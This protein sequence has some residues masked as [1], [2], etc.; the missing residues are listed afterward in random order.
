ME[1]EP[2]RFPSRK[3]PAV[4]GFGT[5]TVTKALGQEPAGPT[6]EELAAA[7]AAEDEAATGKKGKKGSPKGK[8]KGGDDVAD[9]GAAEDNGDTTTDDCAVT[10]LVSTAHRAFIVARDSAHAFLSKAFT[11]QV[12]A[13]LT[14]CFFTERPARCSPIACSVTHALLSPRRRSRT[15]YATMTP[16]GMTKKRGGTTGLEWLTRCATTTRSSRSK[17]D[18]SLKVSL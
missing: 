14:L 3:W 4:Q 16:C 10:S 11:Q 5:L 17:L 15:S 12:R 6:E 2:L 13:P 7:A 8:G 18:L 1:E 9:E